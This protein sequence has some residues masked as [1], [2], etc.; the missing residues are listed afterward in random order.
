[1]SAIS[2]RTPWIVGAAAMLLIVSGCNR[3]DENMSAAGDVPGDTAGAS[4]AMAPAPDAQAGT[5]S[6]DEADDRIEDALRAD[7]T[8]AAFLLDADD[9]RDRVVLEGMVATEAQKSRAAEIA[10]TAAPGITVDDQLRVDAAAASREAAHAAAD[11]AD[12][13]VEDALEAEAALREFDLDVDDEDGRLILKGTVRTDAQRTQAE[14]IAT[15]VAPGIPVDNQIR[16][17]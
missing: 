9:E 14:E 12:D 16:V 13:R 17:E 8:L 3:G 11:E 6:L 1:M 15:R 5:L 2:R 7:P 4:S 10:A